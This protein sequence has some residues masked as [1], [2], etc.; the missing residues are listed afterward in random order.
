M[1]AVRLRAVK[2]LEGGPHFAV[3]LMH[4]LHHGKFI[5]GDEKPFHAEPVAVCPLGALVSICLKRKVF[6]PPNP[7]IQRNA[8]IAPQV[9]Q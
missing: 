9:C 2:Q 1:L 3:L 4:P 8:G 7:S 6:D 5:G